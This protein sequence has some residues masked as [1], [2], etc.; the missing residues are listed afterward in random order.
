MV[1]RDVQEAFDRIWHKEQIFYALPS[2]HILVMDFDVPI[3]GKYSD[4]HDTKM[5]L[6]T[7][8][9]ESHHLTI[10]DAARTT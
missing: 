6:P 10:R 5:S 7:N 2:S 1:F 3:N 8:P 4:I 9:T